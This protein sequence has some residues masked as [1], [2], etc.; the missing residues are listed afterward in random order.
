MRAVFVVALSL[1]ARMAAA[2]SALGEWNAGTPLRTGGQLELG[3]CTIGVTLHGAIAELE[4]RQTI[5]NPGPGEL[6]ATYELELP[7]QAAMIGASFDGAAAIGVPVNPAIERVD[8]T[9]VLGADPV[10]VA[11]VGNDAGRVRY[12]ATVQP[13]RESHEIVLALRWTQTAEI[14]D[15]ALHVK[16]LGR[17]DAAPCAGT[18]KALPGPGATVSAGVA[19]KWG[20]TDEDLAI[21]LGL[22]KAPIAWLQTAELG[23]GETARALTVIAPAVRADTGPH[24]VLF[25]I[26]TSRSMELVGRNNVRQ[27]VRAIMKALP[28]GS[29]IEA[30]LFDR[31]AERVLGSWQPAEAAGNAIDLGLAKHGAVNGSDLVAAFALA[32][33][34]LAEPSETH[35]QAMVIAISDGVLGGVGSDALTKA[36]GGRTETLDIHALILDPHGMTSPDG[37]ALHP[38]VGTYGGTYVELSVDDLDRAI[39]DVAAWLRPAWQDL[40]VKGLEHRTDLGPIPFEVRAGTGFVQLSLGTR[41]HGVAITAHGDATTIAHASLLPAAPIAQLVLA[42]VDDNDLGTGVSGEELRAK[43][44]HRFPSVDDEHDLAVISKVGRVAAG[45]RQMIAGGG[46]YSRMVELPD[47][48]FPPP[49][50]A[51]GPTTGGSALD[52]GIVK[53]MLNDQLQPHAYSCYA[54]SLGRLISLAGTATFEIELGRGEVTSV[55]VTGFETNAEFH[56]CLVD[57]AYGLAPP[58]PTPGYNLDDRSSVSYPLTFSVRDKQPAVAGS[59]AAMTPAAATPVDGQRPKLDVGDTSTPLGNVRP[60]KR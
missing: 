46:P 27:L 54:R 3:T 56:A 23:D 51:I 53:R 55:T 57:A 18:I 39:T 22:G 41:V 17:G 13:I 42:R 7:P 37:D 31:S 49:P 6:A 28:Q 19:F 52:R 38:L 50:I 60:T 30:I 36:L 5:Q 20:A 25:V 15:S 4:L 21:Q 29:T 59:D 32:K 26:D 16:L 10:F 12:R 44:T 11:R 9:D 8:S 34:A 24:R 33:T 2:E 58:M 47:P 14:H 43:L 35:S 45:R 40:T 48:P 1:C